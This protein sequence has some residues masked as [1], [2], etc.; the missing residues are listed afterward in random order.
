MLIS[1]CRRTEFGAFPQDLKQKISQQLQLN[2][3]TRKF[4]LSGSNP[5]SSNFV[6]WV[7]YRWIE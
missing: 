6:C 5:N 4:R 3:L 1:P 2:K 7:S